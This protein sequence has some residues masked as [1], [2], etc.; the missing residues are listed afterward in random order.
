MRG[1]TIS[2]SWRPST[3][4]NVFYTVVRK[5]YAPPNKITD[6]KEVSGNVTGCTYEDTTPLIGVPLYYAVFSGY[7]TLRSA[8]AALLAQPVLVTQSVLSVM[9]RVD[10]Q[11][12]DLNWE[13]PPNVHS[14]VVVRKEQTPPASIGDG[15]RMEDYRP[16]QTRLTDRNVKN[17]QSYYYAFYCQFKDHE[18]RLVLSP[19]EFISATP[20]MP[21][22]PVDHL[23]I[24]STRIDQGYEITISW[25]PPNK[26][27]V[28]IMKTDKPFT[29]PAGKAIPEADLI[30]YGEKLAQHPDSVIEKWANA[31]IAY[32]TRDHLSGECL[33]RNC[34]T[35]RVRGQY[36]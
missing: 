32:Y 20:D 33:Y 31:G 7:D 11:L 22:E 34:A 21:P 1:T 6:G 3:T 14:V 5:S 8:Q 23:D 36:Q 13:T 26:G 4:Q 12:V 10:N 18:G 35:L 30:N 29:L 19:A 15:M 2:L 9:V 24:K 28:I 27:D 16:A 25:Q 17:G